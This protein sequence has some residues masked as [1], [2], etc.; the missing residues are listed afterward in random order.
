[1]RMKCVC[2]TIRYDCF[3]SL[4]LVLVGY[5]YAMEVTKWTVNCWQHAHTIRIINTPQ[6]QTI[7]IIKFHE[8]L[9][10]ID[11]YAET[12][13]KGECNP[14]NPHNF[15]PI[16]RCSWQRMQPSSESGNDDDNDDT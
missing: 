8:T 10:T 15:Y 14:Q 3:F 1:M 5:S 13:K 11:F 16:F 4:V 12:Q 9:S 7:Q 6:E 2:S